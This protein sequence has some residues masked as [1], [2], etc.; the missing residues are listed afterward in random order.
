MA[1]VHRT[2]YLLSI[3]DTP[4]TRPTKVYASVY[5]ILNSF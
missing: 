4:V 2:D 3:L 1:T 5:R